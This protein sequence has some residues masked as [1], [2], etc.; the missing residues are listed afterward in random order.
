MTTFIRPSGQQAGGWVITTSFDLARRD[1]A[2]PLL[3][4]VIGF[5]LVTNLSEMTNY[6]I[7]QFW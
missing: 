1:V 7:E 6:R 5:I 3:T 2:L 4:Y